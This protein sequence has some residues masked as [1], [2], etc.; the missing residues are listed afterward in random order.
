MLSKVLLF[1]GLVF[2]F[3]Y[4][5]VTPI[6]VG[7]ALFQLGE[8]S[9]VLANDGL[10]SGA[11]DIRN[12]L[13]DSHRCPCHH[14]P[15]T[16]SVQSTVTPLYRLASRWF[17]REAVAKINV[18]DNKLRAYRPGRC[19]RSGAVRWCQ[20][21]RQFH[22]PSG[23][24]ELNQTE[25][26]ECQ[27]LGLPVILRRCQPA[28]RIA[29]GACQRCGVRADH[30][31]GNCHHHDCARGAQI[32]PRLHIGTRAENVQEMQSLHDLGVYEIVQP[33]FEGRA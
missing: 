26:D 33:H 12:L 14:S 29:G 27:Q 19:D 9:F 11:L 8:F 23:S 6:A 25:V 15:D 13:V 30:D 3:G 32:N 2:L 17:R 20:V 5:N 1:V 21:L 10:N 7:L 24:I 31:A 16:A 4:R 18:D 22:L 28:I